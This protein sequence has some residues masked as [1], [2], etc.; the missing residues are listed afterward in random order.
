MPVSDQHKDYIKNLPRWQLG[1]DCVEGS[2]AIKEAKATEGAES[3]GGL[4][5]VAGSRYLPPPNVSDNSQ[6]NL[7]RYAAYKQ[8]ASFVNFTGH[9]KDGFTGMIGRKKSTIDLDQSIDYI[10]DNSNELQNLINKAYN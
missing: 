6:E 9:T 2:S 3:T 4:Y 7:N 1:R 5:N 10:E 8:R